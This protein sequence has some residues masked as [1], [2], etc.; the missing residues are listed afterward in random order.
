MK[1]LKIGFA[2]G[3]MDGFSTSGLDMFSEYQK[4]LEKL[5]KT[6]EFEIVNCKRI[7]MTI[8]DAREIREDLDKKG[9]DFLLLFHL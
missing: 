1:K 2:A 8:K 6:M 4:E 5:S 9:V 7:M 3:F